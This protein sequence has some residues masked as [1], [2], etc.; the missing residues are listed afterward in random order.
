M[1]ETVEQAK[2]RQAR[3]ESRYQH[4]WEEI[5]GAWYGTGVWEDPNVGET[6]STRAGIA[7]DVNKLHEALTF[8]IRKHCRILDVLDDRYSKEGRFIRFVV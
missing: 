8:L 5:P 3:K 6:V 1:L 2:A 7:V 4:I